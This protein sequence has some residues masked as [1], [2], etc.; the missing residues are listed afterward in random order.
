MDNQSWC[1][2][3]VCCNLVSLALV[4]DAAV[5]VLMD[6]KKGVIRDLD[7]NVDVLFLG[8]VRFQQK[9]YKI[10][11]ASCAASLVAWGQS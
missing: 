5:V 1:F 8:A 3:K 11:T 2:V 6:A 9:I 10:S 4:R 7:F